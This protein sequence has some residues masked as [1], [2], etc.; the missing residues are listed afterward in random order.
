MD[1]I[2]KSTFK[3]YGIIRQCLEILV[4][5]IE[6]MVPN[7]D[8]GFEKKNSGIGQNVLLTLITWCLEFICL[9]ALSSL[10]FGSFTIK[11]QWT[12]TNDSLSKDST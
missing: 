5:F 4:P 1:K 11:N 3:M 8:P 6:I 12:V 10:L 7:T 9:K 2:L